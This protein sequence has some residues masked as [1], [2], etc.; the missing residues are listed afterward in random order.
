M[1]NSPPPNIVQKGDACTGGL[2]VVEH[3]AINKLRDGQFFGHTGLLTMASYNYEYINY[4]NTYPDLLE[5]E[6][7]S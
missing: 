7:N 6:L 5:T 3:D 2:N 4:L 1:E